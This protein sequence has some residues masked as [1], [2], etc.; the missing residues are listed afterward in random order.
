MIEKLTARLYRSVNYLALLV[1]GD[2][3]ISKEIS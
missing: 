1:D 3:S 2:E